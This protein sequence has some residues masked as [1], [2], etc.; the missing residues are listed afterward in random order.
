MQIDSKKH[1]PLIAKL[2]TNGLAEFEDITGEKITEIDFD[3]LSLKNMLEFVKI[4]I[5]PFAK[6]LLTGKDIGDIVDESAEGLVWL[7]KTVAGLM[8]EY[9][10]QAV[11]DAEIPAGGENPPDAGA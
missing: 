9:V 1:G 7:K 8:N 11:K 4:S 10:P 6:K 5:N 2:T 3:K